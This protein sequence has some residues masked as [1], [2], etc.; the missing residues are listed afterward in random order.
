MIVIRVLLSRKELLAR[1]TVGINLEFLLR[2]NPFK[3]PCLNAVT[4]LLCTM[5]VSQK[6]MLAIIS[7]PLDTLRSVTHLEER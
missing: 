2:A 4:E 6:L 1:I 7:P 5:R 3:K